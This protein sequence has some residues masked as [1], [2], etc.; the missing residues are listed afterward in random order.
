MDGVLREFGDS[1]DGGVSL[2]YDFKEFRVTVTA[3]A[4]TPGLRQVSENFNPLAVPI[5]EIGLTDE[6]DY[7]IQLA[8]SIQED[9]YRV[10]QNVVEHY[11]ASEKKPPSGGLAG[12]VIFTGH[13]RGGAIADLAT[14]HLAEAS[15]SFHGLGT[16]TFGQVFAF[17]ENLAAYVD[18]NLPEER[19]VKVCGEG[20][21]G[22]W[23]RRGAYAPTAREQS[24]AV[25][26][27]RKSHTSFEDDEA[28]LVGRALQVKKDLGDDYAK[29]GVPK[30]MLSGEIMW[31]KRGG[32]SQLAKIGG[33]Q[34]NHSIETYIAE[35]GKNAGVENSDDEE[36]L[37]EVAR[38]AMNSSE[39][40][41]KRQ[42]EEI[43]RL[44]KRGQP[45]IDDDEEEAEE[46]DE[47]EEMS[48]V[49]AFKRANAQFAK[50]R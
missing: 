28:A 42:L 5:S 1:P 4:G 33:I 44:M 49:E 27:V 11:L 46:A 25:S 37:P 38:N 47:E 9:S 23:L 15:D 7:P 22:P 17:S 16:V 26:N 12:P 2:L 24:R 13:S 45:S 20:D 32:L 30:Y 8:E 48:T 36:D 31:I 29:L 21:V 35:M 41:A 43:N 6:N 10:N 39:R 14:L 50:R 34:T 18:A 19:A 40:E 3:F